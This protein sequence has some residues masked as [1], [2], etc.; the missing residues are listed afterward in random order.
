MP[1]AFVIVRDARG[2]LV[3]VRRQDEGECV[4]CL[5]V[6]FTS[7]ASAVE[8]AVALQRAFAQRSETTEESIVVRM[9]LNVGAP[10]EEEN[11]FFG[12]AVILGARI[13]DQASGGEIL[14]PERRSHGD[15]T[16]PIR[17][18]MVTRHPHR[19]CATG[20]DATSRGRLTGDGRRARRRHFSTE[21][22]HGD[23]RWPSAVTESG[24]V[25][26]A[27]S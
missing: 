16:R 9:G 19:R 18:R 2:S 25:K 12:S 21:L 22:G 4:G 11:D 27:R 7:V 24:I 26:V 10:I 13:K 6:S 14:V 15:G 23:R 3:H 5:M 1:E 8:C 17:P 20:R